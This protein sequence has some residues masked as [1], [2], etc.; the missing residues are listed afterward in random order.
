MYSNINTLIINN[1]V[2]I[3]INVINNIICNKI[4]FN[5]KKEGTFSIC[6]TMD[7]HGIYMYIYIFFLWLHLEH[8]EVP[9]LGV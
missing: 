9:M 3:L 1:H 7:E 2:Y 6:D 5:L 4:L 8:R